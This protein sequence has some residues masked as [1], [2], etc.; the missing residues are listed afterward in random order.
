MRSHENQP[1]P[2]RRD[3]LQMVAAAFGLT[4]LGPLERAV[5]AESRPTRARRGTKF[6]VMVEL[7]GGNDWL[8][9]VVPHT[10]PSY[11]SQRPGLALDPSETLGLDS[12]P[13]ATSDFRMHPNLVD[14]AQ[15]YRDGE[16]AIVRKVGYPG[17][18]KS[19]DKSKK[20]WA[21]GAREVANTSGWIAR[22]AELEAPTALGAVSVG[23]GRHRAFV[24]GSSNPLALGSLARFRY[25]EDARYR[26]NH[27]HRVAII[28]DLLE[29]R[30]SGATRDVMLTGHTL[31]SQIQGALSGYSSPVTYRAGALSVRLLDVA[32]MVQ[33]G[34]ETRVYYTRLKGFD[35]HGAQAA[36]HATLLQALDEGIK[37]LADDLKQM[38]VWNDAAIVM[39]SEFGRRNFSNGSGGTDHGEAGMMMVAGGTVAGGL[40]G[41]VM[42]DA[43]VAARN[44]AY[45]MDFRAVYADLVENHLGMADASPVFAEALEIPT[46]PNLVL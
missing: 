21:Q 33:A 43:D 9:T 19:H 18:N 34:F 42:V 35:T 25:D 28:K 44:L 10:L 29:Q 17:P 45:G 37:D 30:A 26:N 41:P 39:M 6:L 38:G 36:R 23:V 24:G 3:A 27:R 4:A 11:A 14:L 16:V 7:E 13:Y 1:Q 15:M 2:T 8:N 22:Y 12:G 5:A 31:A 40:H 46:R 32:R 20:I